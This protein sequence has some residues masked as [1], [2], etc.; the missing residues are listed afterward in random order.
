M[1]LSSF[2]LSLL[3]FPLPPPLSLPLSSGG[4]WSVRIQDQHPRETD[5]HQYGGVFSS[6]VLLVETAER[7]SEEDPGA[8]GPHPIGEHATETR[9]H[10]GTEETT[11]GQ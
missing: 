10:S 9:T 7:T 1:Y 11:T 4:P 8:G 2:P 6:T 3:L 5:H